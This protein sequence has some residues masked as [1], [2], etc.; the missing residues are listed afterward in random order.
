MAGAGDNVESWLPK[1]RAGSHH[2]LGEA[3]EACRA[4][5]LMVAE[6]ELD[7]KLKAKGG[8]SDIVQETFLEA[9]RDFARFHGDSEDELLA[10]LRRLLLNNLADFRR[11]YRGTDK[12]AANLEVA[13]DAG[14][15]SRDWK[16]TLAAEAPTPSGEMLRQ[17]GAAEL[18]RAIDRLPEDYRLVIRFRYDDELPFEEIAK[19]MH[20]TSNATRKLFARAVERLQQELERPE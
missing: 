11:R 17:E 5:L 7:Q 12:R 6:R 4:Y 14:G 9:Q 13:L 8:A 10:W 16:S 15:S 18:E 3:L 2:A 20:R 19:K 1:A